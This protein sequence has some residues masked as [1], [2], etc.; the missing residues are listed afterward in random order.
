MDETWTHCKTNTN[1]EASSEGNVRNSKTG[2][3][4]KKNVNKQGYETVC[5]HECGKS[6]SKK[7]HR[8]IAEAFTDEDISNMDV[9]H[10]DKNRQNNRLDNL[11]IRTRQETVADTYSNGRKQT[12]KMRPVKCL[13]TGESFESITACSKAMGVGKQAISRSANNP[14]LC[15]REGLHFVSL[16][17][18][19]EEED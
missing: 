10:I 14:Y 5:L 13:E 19:L 1:Y 6:R 2:R 11:V 15:T 16:D 18:I 3:I 9:A 8:L 4:M 12:H 17:D 7:V